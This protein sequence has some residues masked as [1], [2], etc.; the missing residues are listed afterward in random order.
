[1]RRIDE[2]RARSVYNHDKKDIQRNA[3]NEASLLV[4]FFKKYNFMLH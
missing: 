1:M 4:T 2:E 3:S